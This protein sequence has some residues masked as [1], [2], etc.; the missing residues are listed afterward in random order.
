VEVEEERGKDEEG[1][2]RWRGR[3]GVSVKPAEHDD[4]GKRRRRRTNEE[5]GF[6]KMEETWD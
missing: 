2:G 3:G 1:G 4:G 6:V 5:G